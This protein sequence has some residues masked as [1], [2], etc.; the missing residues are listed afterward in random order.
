M[1]SISSRKPTP[2]HR[3]LLALAASRKIIQDSTTQA[4]LPYM[5]F[6]HFFSHAYALDLEPERMETLVSGV[7]DVV[8]L[9]HDEVTRGLKPAGRVN[10]GGGHMGMPGLACVSDAF[11]SPSRHV[12]ETP[13]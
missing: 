1:R 5:A 9:V 8:D 13:V 4:L 2:C 10:P 11:L 6:R 3:D 7:S 12:E